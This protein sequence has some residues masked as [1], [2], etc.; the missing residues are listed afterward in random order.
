[1]VSEGPTLSSAN[2][3]GFGAPFTSIL[4]VPSVSFAIA[5]PVRSRLAV[6][7]ESLKFTDVPGLSFF[8]ATDSTIDMRLAAGSHENAITTSSDSDTSNSS[9]GASGLS[10]NVQ[11]RGSGADAAPA[12]ANA[13]R[14]VQGR[15]VMALRSLV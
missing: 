14:P 5:S 10:S 13:T 3:R 7:A 15:R 6:P 11:V 12:G 4:T 1:M 8:E 2:R 9:A